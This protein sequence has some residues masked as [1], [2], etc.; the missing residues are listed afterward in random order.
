MAWFKPNRTLHLK[1]H[2]E[3]QPNKPV[4][5]SEPFQRYC[6]E[7]GPQQQDEKVFEKGLQLP[8]SDL[9]AATFTFRPFCCRLTIFR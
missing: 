7:S 1:L 4:L 8:L 3:D 2:V 5:N 6:K 9:F